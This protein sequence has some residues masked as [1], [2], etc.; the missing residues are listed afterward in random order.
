MSGT[1]SRA[2]VRSSLSRH[3]WCR[4]RE[5]T[6]PSVWS[7][8]LRTDGLMSLVTQ[9][10][11]SLTTDNI[12]LHETIINISLLKSTIDMSN[13]NQRP[14]PIPPYPGV[15]PYR[16][17]ARDQDDQDQTE[18]SPRLLG[19]EHRPVSVG[20]FGPPSTQTVPGLAS[21]HLSE[22][23][24]RDKFYAYWNRQKVNYLSNVRPRPWLAGA[25]SVAIAT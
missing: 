7:I 25:F 2:S 24:V 17:D 16:V 3:Q 5:A 11:S 20:S 10:H 6:G 4:A 22:E 1:K 12:A 13:S 21:H 14:L 23:Q 18:T 9:S 8:V 19:I 15:I